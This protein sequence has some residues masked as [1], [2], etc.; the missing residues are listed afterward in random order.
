MKN[1]N[2]S[3]GCDS[4]LILYSDFGFGGRGPSCIHG[5]TGRIADSDRNWVYQS[6][7]RSGGLRLCLKTHLDGLPTQHPT[8]WTESLDQTSTITLPVSYQGSEY[9]LDYYCFDASIVTPVRFSMDSLFTSYFTPYVALAVSQ[10]PQTST[11]YNSFC[12]E[13]SSHYGTLGFIGKNSTDNTQV[14][15]HM[16][17]VDTSSNI[18]W[19]G[20]YVLN[21]QWDNGN[22]IV[23]SDNFSQGLRF[24]NVTSLADGSWLVTVIPDVDF[25]ELMSE[26]T[27]YAGTM[28]YIGA[29]GDHAMFVEGTISNCSEWYWK[30]LKINKEQK[31]YPNVL[32]SSFLYDNDNTYSFSN[33]YVKRINDNVPDIPLLFGRG[34]LPCGR[35]CIND[36][37][38]ID[39]W[40]QVNTSLPEHSAIIVH[41][42]ADEDVAG[43][44]D[45]F[46]SKSSIGFLGCVII[47]GQASFIIRYGS[48]NEDGTFLEAGTGSIELTDSNGN[49]TC[50]GQNLPTIWE[51]S[52]GVLQTDGSWLITLNSI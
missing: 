47:N 24:D 21:L 42:P 27:N 7:D 44:S 49:V 8:R 11:N 48:L 25:S 43:M 1:I 29:L 22:V 18:T 36:Q 51:F 26:K 35:R 38:V 50:V 40:L 39:V 9:P 13:L 37:H 5:D 16:G 32:Y 10:I 12:S 2:Q 52:P 17:T 31:Q 15:L 23:T 41:D 3:A 20:V 34:Q 45:F 19:N 46:S 30:S 14:S 4:F 33:Y 6:V 28:E